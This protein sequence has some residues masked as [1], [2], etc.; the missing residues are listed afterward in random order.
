MTKRQPFYERGYRKVKEAMYAAT[1]VANRGGFLGWLGRATYL[2][3]WSTMLIIIC[4]I[5]LLTLGGK[6]I[7]QD[8]DTKESK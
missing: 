7:K 8:N 4:T 1:E 6:L 2:A 5:W 3:I